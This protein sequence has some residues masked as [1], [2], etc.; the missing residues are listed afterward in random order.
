MCCRRP[1]ASDAT[2]ME[3]PAGI[4]YFEFVVLGLNV[5]KLFIRIF[6]RE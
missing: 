1:Q 3:I 5:D 6:V 4:I 2:I